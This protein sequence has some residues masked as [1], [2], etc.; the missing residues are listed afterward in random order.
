MDYYSTI[1][2]NEALVYAIIWMNLENIKPSERSHTQKITCCATPLLWN[3]QNRAVGGW[4]G[5]EEKG[6]GGGRAR[7]DVFFLS[8]KNVP[9]FTVV[10]TARFFEHTESALEVGEPYEMWTIVQKS[11]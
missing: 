11:L 7:E 4:L 5:L 1:K 6:G 10:L 3:V 8:N 2:R 9:K